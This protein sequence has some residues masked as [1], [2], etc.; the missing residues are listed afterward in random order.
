MIEGGG[1]RLE[2]VLVRKP[3]G[4]GD[5]LRSDGAAAQCSHLLEQAQSVSY[6]PAGVG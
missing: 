5:G 6:R 2:G 3:E 4:V 1:E